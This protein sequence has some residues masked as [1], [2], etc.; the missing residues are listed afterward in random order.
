MI[1][2][3]FKIE[4]MQLEQ[5]SCLVRLFTDVSPQEN[6]PKEVSSNR[7][8]KQMKTGACWWSTL[9]KKPFILGGKQRKKFSITKKVSRNTALTACFKGHIKKQTK[10]SSSRHAASSR[11]ALNWRQ[12]EILLSSSKLSSQRHQHEHLFARACLTWGL[13]NTTTFVC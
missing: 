2:L 7:R 5:S 10:K 8:K 1:L 12:T 11:Y 3:V 4:G 13:P 9:H 6:H